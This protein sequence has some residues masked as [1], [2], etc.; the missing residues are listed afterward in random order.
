MAVV[1]EV[2]T[3]AYPGEIVIER[4]SCLAAVAGGKR[5]E[6][7]VLA[8]VIDWDKR[9]VLMRQQR[10]TEQHRVAALDRVEGAVAVQ[11]RQQDQELDGIPG[12]PSR[13]DARGETR[14][15]EFPSFRCRKNG[16]ALTY[17]YDAFSCRLIDTD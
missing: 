2:Q 10:Q 1:R 7:A 9:C 5:G 14:C 13:F 6:D 17:C 16:S 3:V 12:V 8:G 4:R 15:Q 11:M